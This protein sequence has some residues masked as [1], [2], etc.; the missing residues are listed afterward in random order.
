MLKKELF[1]GTISISLVLLAYLLPYTILA[2]VAKWY[3]SFLLWT[4]IALLVI[5][6][7]NIITKDWGA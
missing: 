2:N 5:G 4:V 1:W 6:V 3:G 7:N